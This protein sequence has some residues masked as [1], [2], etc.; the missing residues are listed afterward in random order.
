M[1]TV[2]T[3]VRNGRID[4]PAPSDIPD[5]TEVMLTI[6]ASG[7]NAPLPP[8]EIAR[9]LAAMKTLPPWDIPEAI[10]ADHDDWERT[11]NMGALHSL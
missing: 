6:A 8:E 10:A 11:S 5:G 1:T 9:V 4:V 7:E 3:T 2:K